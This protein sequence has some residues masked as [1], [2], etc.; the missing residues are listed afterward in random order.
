M[1]VQ[2]VTD[3]EVG[4]RGAIAGLLTDVNNPS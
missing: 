2:I 3:P 1:P 4:L